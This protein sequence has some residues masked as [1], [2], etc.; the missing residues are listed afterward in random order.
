M[1]FVKKIDADGTVEGNH[2][3]VELLMLMTYD[4]GA[5]DGNDI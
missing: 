4:D 5:V 2:M 3:M 1:V